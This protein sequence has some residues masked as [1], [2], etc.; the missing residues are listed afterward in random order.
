MPNLAV[1]VQPLRAVLF[2]AVGTLLFAE[3]SV[4]DVYAKSAGSVARMFRRLRLPPDSKPQSPSRM[5]STARFTHY[6]RTN[7]ARSTAGGALSPRP[8]VQR[9]MWSAALKLLW[10]HFACPRAGEW[11]PLPPKLFELLERRKLLWGLASN[12]DGR[13]P[14]ICR[15]IPSLANCRHVFV[16]SQV[17]WRKPSPNF[18]RAIENRLGFPPQ[19]LLLVGDDLANDYLAARSAGWQA[20]AGRAA[21]LAGDEARLAGLR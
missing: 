16:S 10:Q 14:A 1:D 11:R 5:N 13:L 17:G 19:S 3:P 2:D 21:D 6:A 9:L 12:F 8:W 18:F 20:A 15:G 7:L 4:V